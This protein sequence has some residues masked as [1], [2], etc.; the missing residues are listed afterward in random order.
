MNPKNLITTLAA[1]LLAAGTARTQPARDNGGDLPLDGLAAQ[2]VSQPGR[3]YRPYVW[4]HWMGSNF[5]KEGI[6]KDLEAMAEAGIGGATIFNLASAVQ[7]SHKPVGNNP[8][9]DRTYRSAAYWDA[10]R[11]AAAEAARLGLKIGIQNTPGYSTTG[12]P[13]ITEERG[14]QTIVSSCQSAEGGK[15]ISLKLEQ[16]VP[17]VYS[18][19]GSP[20][21]KAT[22]YRDI[23]VLAVPDGAASAD[24]V[25]DVSRHMRRDGTFRWDAPAGRWTI[26][27]LGYGPTMSNPHPLPDELIGRAL[28]ADKMSE[29]QSVYHWNNFLKPLKRNLKEYIGS[30]FDHVLIDSYEAGGQNW[31]KDFRTEFIRSKGYDPVPF[32]ALAEAGYSGPETERFMKDYDAQ[33]RRLFM[34]KGWKVARRMINRAG[35]GFY[36]EPYYGPFDTYAAVEVAD[37]PMGEFWTGGSGA[38]S[39]DIVKAAAEYG[40]KIV[41]AEAFTG[42]PQI[43]KYTEDPEFLK[44]SAD[45]CFVSGANRLFLH[46]WVHQPFDDRY[47]PAM[48]MGW[49]GTH[50]G[51]NQ[52]WIGPAKAFFN[53]LSRCQMMLQQGRFVS[54][55]NT[56]LHRSTADAEIY[57]VINATGSAIDREFAFETPYDTAPELWDAYHGTIVKPRHWAK[58]GGTICV[59]LTLRP[60]ESLFVVSPESD[61]GYPKAEE[62]DVIKETREAICGPWQVE[63]R[64]KLRPAFTRQLDSL[65]DFSTSEDEALKYFSG[66]AVYSKTIRISAAQAAHGKRILLDFGRMNDI[67]ELKVN[68][69]TVMVLWYP[70]YVADITDYIHEGE[71]AI[72]L[73]VTN[74]WANRLIGDEQ[75][76]ADFEWGEDR[77]ESGRAMKAF[78][79]WFVEGRER[80]ES[81]RVGFLIWYYHRKDSPLQPAGLCGPAAIIEETVRLQE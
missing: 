31:T 63:F 20:H 35:L 55:D 81:N 14:M 2:F 67:A 8:W 53:Y 7:E 45:G 56:V 50:F 76:P 19:W 42:P 17:P 37:L 49:W 18:G 65:V 64:P 24:R 71:N 78:P 75:Y 36:W 57:F 68:G 6:T 10:M 11:H 4:W 70:P 25:I 26:V 43:S 66:T 54:T 16:P 39:A 29:R 59:R 30:S 38:I 22:Y 47:Q 79:Q 3:Q 27:R 13:W 60:H 46:H 51:R 69:R 48:G 80:P 72:E 61:T 40:K 44:P 1:A 73:A 9:P 12:G 77:G 74:N 62:A 15:A 21:I 23:A 41:G 34:D 32:I 52:T 33:I 5:S 58:R 28:E